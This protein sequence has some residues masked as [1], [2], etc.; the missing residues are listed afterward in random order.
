MLRLKAAL[1][2]VNVSIQMADI[3]GASEE[4][5][6]LLQSDKIS[7]PARLAVAA[8]VVAIVVLSL[9]PYAE[10]PE[11]GM[12]K[13]FEHFIAY[14]GA[15][16]F[17]PLAA[18]SLRQR[19]LGWSCLAVASGV[20]EVAQQLSPGRTPGLSDALAS[21]SGLTAGVLFGA[22]VARIAAAH[23]ARRPM[24]A[25]AAAAAVQKL[26]ELGKKA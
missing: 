10:R 24:A 3:Q 11:T 9:V 8:C 16:F 13:E 15:G 17:L 6:G 26:R 7:R 4:P 14:A 19:L 23:I 25:I 5:A 20:L 22:L 12:P 21:A 18:S 2:T 1:A